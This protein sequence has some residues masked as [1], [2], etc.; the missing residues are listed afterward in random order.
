[1]VVTGIQLLGSVR[2]RLTLTA[3]FSSFKLLRTYLLALY[4]RG[5][6]DV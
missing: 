4:K 6:N 1:M 5:H 3:S 2:Y